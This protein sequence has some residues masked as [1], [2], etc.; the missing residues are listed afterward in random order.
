M[1]ED[2][3]FESSYSKLQYELT[4][5]ELKL[6]QARTQRNEAMVR[7]GELAKE[8]QEAKAPESKEAE[9]ER[10]RKALIADRL[11]VSPGDFL[12]P[13]VLKALDERDHLRAELASLRE[14]DSVPVKVRWTVTAEDAAKMMQHIKAGIC[15][16]YSA[17]DDL[18]ENYKED[19]IKTFE[20][21][22]PRL[23][24]HSVI[25]VPAGV[26]SVPELGE[27]ARRANL[28]DSSPGYWNTV[29]TAIRDRILAGLAQPSSNAG[30]F[31]ADEVEA[32]AWV[33][34]GVRH[35]GWKWEQAKEWSLAQARAAIAHM[36]KRP[37]GLPT[38]EQLAQIYNRAYYDSA[39]EKCR[40]NWESIPEAC[41]EDMVRGIDA[42]LTELAPFLRDPVGW[43]LD[44]TAQQIITTSKEAHDKCCETADG[45]NKSDWE[46]A[47][48]ILDLCRSSIR[49]TF[50][51]KECAKWKAERDV[52]YR[53][54]DDC[55]NRML[56]VRLALNE[57]SES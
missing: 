30:Q 56:K 57:G 1:S 3:V 38:R 13:H 49:P 53:D 20:K 54:W 2:K 31:D 35:H 21:L 6:H 28:E 39:P 15:D 19:F 43:K 46:V 18:G 36:R 55:R 44:V 29:A 41:R 16:A 10:E 26:P 48:A 33:I 23:A 17:W 45:I 11:G 50:E 12:A 51:C 42:I 40:V 4:E 9:D 14:R 25:D 22:L 52:M 34:Y 8:L 32:L 27:I 7:V 37:E 5:A 24:A 47:C